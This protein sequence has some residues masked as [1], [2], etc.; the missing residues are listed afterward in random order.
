MPVPPAKKLKG[1]TQ[2]MLY[3]FYPSPVV[4]NLMAACAFTARF[5]IKFIP[6]SSSDTGGNN[7]MGDIVYPII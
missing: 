3:Q 4:L 1:P 2:R 5:W 6:D 7:F